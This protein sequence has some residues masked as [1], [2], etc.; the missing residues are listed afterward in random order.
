MCCMLLSTMLNCVCVCAC[1]CACACVCVGV[2]VGVGDYFIWTQCI[3]LK[4][5]QHYST[6]QPFQ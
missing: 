6:N 2:G 1:V 4:T 3:N 5:R